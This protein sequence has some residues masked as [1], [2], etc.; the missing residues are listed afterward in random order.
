MNAAHYESLKK[1]NALSEDLSRRIEVRLPMAR[2]RH[3]NA[4][5]RPHP[6]IRLTRSSRRRRSERVCEAR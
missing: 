3:L 5:L 2:L 6:F 4:I 1:G